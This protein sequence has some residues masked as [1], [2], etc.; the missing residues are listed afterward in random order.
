MYFDLNVPVVPQKIGIKQGSEQPL[1]KKSKLGEKSPR[2]AHARDPILSP[3]ERKSIE[4]RID[5]LIN[6]GYSVIALN[7]TVTSKYDPMSDH[8]YLAEIPD[9][10]GVTLLRRLTIELDERSENG[11]G[12]T[13]N[14]SSALSTYDIISLRPSTAANLSSACL[15]HS[16]ASPITAHI[17]SLDLSSQSRLPFFLKRSLIN[18][19]IKNGAAFE[20]CYGPAVAVGGD[21][22]NRRNW[23]ANARE[24][25]RA[26]SGKGVLLSGGGEGCEV[27]GPKDV[28]NLATIL[29]MKQD[30]ALHAVTTLAKSV[31]IRAQTRKTYRAVLS[32]PTLVQPTSSVHGFITAT[33]GDQPSVSKVNEADELAAIGQ[34][35]TEGLPSQDATTTTIAAEHG[36]KKRRHLDEDPI[37]PSTSPPKSKKKRKN[38]E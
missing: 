22:I 29:G 19:A 4:T 38:K 33:S 21:E 28:I 11:F 12:L 2:V 23:W 8:N 15:S 20:I 36:T 13:N 14:N 3:S 9:R 24:V 35:T 5:D 17:I 30:Q 37:P 1:K 6:L 18:T 31:T 10:S 27:R 34:T 32:E 7:Q 16:V 26:T 25:V